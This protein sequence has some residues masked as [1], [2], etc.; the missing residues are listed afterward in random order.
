MIHLF[1]K[2]HRVSTW[3]SLVR[4]G[5]R[6]KPCPGTVRGFGNKGN[7]MTPCPSELLKSLRLPEYPNC[8]PE[9][10]I[11]DIYRAH[12]TSILTEVTG[13]E[14]SIIYPA[15]QWTQTLDKGDLI[16]PVPA[17]RVKG[18]KPNDLASEWIDKVVNFYFLRLACTKSCIKVP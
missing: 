4:A 6:Q 3:L 14:A 18:K 2:L 8:Y 7:K 5:N 13:V 15:L 12:L 17:L 9:Y 10:N 11:V 1:S 16:L